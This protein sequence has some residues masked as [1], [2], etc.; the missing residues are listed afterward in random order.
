MPDP[1]PKPEPNQEPE[2][3]PSTAYIHHL[4]VLARSMDAATL[5]AALEFHR[6]HVLVLSMEMQ[7][8]LQASQRSEPASQ[9]HRDAKS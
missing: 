2:T 7:A 8:R 1:E 4:R 9:R 6:M 3:A 5:Q